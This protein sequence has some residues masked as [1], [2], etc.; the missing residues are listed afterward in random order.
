MVIINDPQ[1]GE[2]FGGAVAAPVFAS[3]TAD[4]L[5]ML[6]IPP[7]AKSGEQVVAVINGKPGGA[8]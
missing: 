3:V 8:T 6:K 4:A 2:Y 1:G 7:K 5:R